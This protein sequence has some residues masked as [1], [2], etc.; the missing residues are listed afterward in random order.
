VRGNDL[1]CDS[2]VDVVCIS[3]CMNN[4][5]IRCGCTSRGMGQP[6]DRWFCGGPPQDCQ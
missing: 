5:R 3:D 2:N 4:S 6:D 1:P